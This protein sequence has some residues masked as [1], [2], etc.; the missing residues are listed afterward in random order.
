MLLKKFK[1]MFADVS[2]PASTAIERNAKYAMT[3]DPPQRM[4]V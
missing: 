1:M 4:S 2:L 3:A